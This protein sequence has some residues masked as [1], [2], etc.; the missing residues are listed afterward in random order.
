MKL[1]VYMLLVLVARLESDFE[2]SYVLKPESETEQGQSLKSK[3]E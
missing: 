2:F 3:K 1:V